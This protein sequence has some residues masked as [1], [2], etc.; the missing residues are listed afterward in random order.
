MLIIL[1]LMSRISQFCDTYGIAISD[2]LKEDFVQSYAEAAVELTFGRDMAHMAFHMANDNK[3]KQ[4]TFS[5]IA[6]IF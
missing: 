3:A 5:V 2:V 6:L 1:L 4:T